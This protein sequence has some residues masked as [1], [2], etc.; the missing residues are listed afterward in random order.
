ML[1]TAGFQ[2]GTMQ[3]RLIKK[4]GQEVSVFGANVIVYDSELNLVLNFN[5]GKFVS[6]YEAI[7]ACAKHLLDL[8]SCKIEEFGKFGQILASPLR[9]NGETA[10]VILVDCDAISGPSNHNN[11]ASYP[12]F[13]RQILKMFISSLNDTT[14]NHQQIEFVSNELA[15][16]Y[17]ELMLLYK[18]SANMKMTQSD[19]NYLQMACDNL[20]ELVNVEGIAIFLEKKVGDSRRLILTAGTGLI[21]IDNRHENMHEILFERLMAELKNGSDALLDSEVDAPFKYEWFGKVKNIIAV[22]LHGKDRIIGMMVA[23]NRLNKADFDSI[24]G[25]LF[26]SVAN[27]CAVFIENQSLFRELKELFIGSLKALTSSIDAKDQYTRGHSERVAMISKWI[28]EHY[29]HATGELASDDIQKIY[30]AG[31]LHDIGKIGISEAVLGKKGKLTEEEYDQIKTHPTIGA[32]ILSEIR[33]MVDVVP[34]VLYHHERYD[35]TGYPKGLSGEDIPLAGKIVMIADAFD[36]MTSKRTYREALDIDTAIAEIENGIGGQ[37][38]PE[39]GSIFLNSNISKL[40]EIIQDGKL[41]SYYTDG[42]SDYGTV[43][44]GALLR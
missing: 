3:L 1:K 6:D 19:S 11:Q 37:F 16:T 2:L 8:Q 13:M 33:Q 24:D 22:P 39:I 28:A 23:T 14:K 10:A 43:A 32:G 12:K 27:E 42:V 36:A 15:Q 44:V 40:W 25:K 35:G 26:N 41:E 29:S 7:V 31:L 17:E 5:G 30:L 34:G 38:D 20:T 4:F 18:M 21:A 9:I